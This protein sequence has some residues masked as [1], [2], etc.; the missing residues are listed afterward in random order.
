MNLKQEKRIN[1]Q[2]FNPKLVKGERGLM[3]NNK[4]IHQE[5]I[6]FINIYSP[7]VYT[8][9]FINLILLEINGSIGLDS[10]TNSGPI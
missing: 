9:S 1:R 8:S 2:N 7:T 5:N 6:T 10:I 3:K 4:A